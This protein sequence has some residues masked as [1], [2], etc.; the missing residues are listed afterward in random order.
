MKVVSETRFVIQIL[1]QY[2]KISAEVCRL[3]IV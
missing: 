2:V 3:K 1:S